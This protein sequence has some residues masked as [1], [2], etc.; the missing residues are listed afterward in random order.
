MPNRPI[1]LVVATLLV[2]AT[3]VRPGQTQGQTDWNAPFPPHKVIDNIYFI[4]TD[5]LGS[6]LVTTAAG[7]ILVNSDFESTVPFLRKNVEALGFRF[8]DIRII[9]GSHAHGDH[10][11]G[12]AMLKE[13]TGGQVMAME[14]DVPALRAMRP[15]GKPHPIDRILHDGD[16]VELGGETLTAYRTPGH[17]KGNTS[18]WL[19]VQEGGRTYKLVNNPDYPNQAQDYMAMYKRVRSLPVD[20]FLGAHGRFYGLAGKYERLKTRKEG[21]PNPFVDRPGYLAHIDLQEGNFQK[22]LKEQTAAA[23]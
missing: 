10:M 18:W 23:R 17:T 13:L 4:G 1:F 22:M 19:E 14:D 15:G 2:A 11:E 5:Q 7:H 3:V 12:D 20:V 9:L 21:D 6:F 8:T 16:K